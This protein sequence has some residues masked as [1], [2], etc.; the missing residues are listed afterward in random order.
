MGLDK[1]MFAFLAD[2]GIDCPAPM[3]DKDAEEL[4]DGNENSDTKTTKVKK[5][6]GPAS[7]GIWVGACG[8]DLIPET[9]ENTQAIDG[10][11][12]VGEEDEMIWW[13][14]DGKFVGFSE[15]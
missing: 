7:D 5:P 12:D 8:D 3:V 6:R 15:W 14:W 1:A 11:D 2:S 4:P 13:E 9:I 10:N